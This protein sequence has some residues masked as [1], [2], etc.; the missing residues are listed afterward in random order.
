MPF[1]IPSQ[2]MPS[3]WSAL[4]SATSATRTSVKAATSTCPGI[5]K[6][7]KKTAKT[8]FSSDPPMIPFF[9]GPSSKKLLIHWT[10]SCTSFL[11]EGISWAGHFRNWSMK[12]RRCAR[13]KAIPH[14]SAFYYINKLWTEACCL[15]LV[16]S[17]QRLGID[18]KWYYVKKGY[19]WLH[20]NLC[21]FKV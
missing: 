14:L 8:S 6:S 9:P 20:I 4:T 11:I 13:F 17:E 2:F 5:G 3:F 15:S 18:N 19:K 12:S 10:S 1:L 7:R 21:L 16:L